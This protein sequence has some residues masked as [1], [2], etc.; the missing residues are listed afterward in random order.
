LVECKLN[1]NNVPV[2]SPGPKDALPRDDIVGIGGNCGPSLKW[3][4]STRPDFL[5]GG[6][7]GEGDIGESGGGGGSFS[8]RPGMGK[9][10]AE[11][12]LFKLDI[13]SGR[14]ISNGRC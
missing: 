10:L 14:E 12:T 9:G 6:G 8:S 4:F 2:N 5:G 7:G 13:W 3:V 1:V 11:T